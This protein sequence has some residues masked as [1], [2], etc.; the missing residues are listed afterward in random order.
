MNSKRNIVSAFILL[1]ILSGVFLL[2]KC[3]P[4][5]DKKIAELQT[6]EFTGDKTCKSC[7]EKEFT[8]WMQSHHFMAMQPATDSTVSGDFNNKTFTADGVTSRFYKKDGKFFINTVGEDGKNHDY[9]VKYTF[10]FTPLQQYLIEFPGGRMQATRQSWDVKEKKWF[11][12]YRAQN[13]SPGD[14][15]HWTGNGQNWNTMCASCH[16][17]NLQ[18][19]YHDASDSYKTSWSVINVSC[20]SCHGAGK[21]HIDYINSDEYK[22]G[23]RTDG[24]FLLLKKGTK[25]LA[26]INACAPCHARKSDFSATLV[27]SEELLDN[28]LPEIPTTE[29]FYAD[30]QVN[31]E[32]YIYTSFLQSKMFHRDVKCSNCHNPHSGKILFNDNRL[33][34]QCHAK[35]YD[36][37]FHTFHKAGTVQSEC[38]SCHMP[39][40]YYM[41]IDYR[42]DHSF[43]VPRPD[44]S[45]KYNIPNAC[46]NCHKDK[47]YQWAADA[48]VKWYG[49]NRRYH[50]SDNLIPGSELNAASESHL[51]KLLSDTAVPNIVKA[52]AANYLGNIPTQGSLQALLKCLNESDA[53]IRYRA[54]RSLANFPAQTWQQA[55][56]P[57]LTDKVIAVRVGTANLFIGLPEQQI[58]AQYLAAYNSARSELH[59]Y[60]MYQ[61]DFS[62]GNMMIA[63]YYLQLKDYVN[64]EKYY[65]KGLKKDNL[66]N[67]ARLNLSTVY[68]LM[69]RNEDALKVLDDA[70]KLDPGND[71]AYYN[72]GLLLYEMKRN[73]EAEKSFAKAVGLKS[74]N[75]R[76]YYNYGLLLKEENKLKE[77]ET[78]LKKGISINP[79]DAGL[80]YALVF[81]Y[82]EANDQS[83]ARSAAAKLK[84]MDPNNPE[85]ISLFKN[86]GL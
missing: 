13:I 16:S 43:R 4:Q 14:W 29:H 33:C 53:Q 77:A 82:I 74:Q 66:M 47:S 38:K 2:Q 8:E 76:V 18:K 39:G 46:N 32:D 44:Q 27:S 62:V 85:Y 84:Q 22:N 28:Y 71:R 61:A 58:P 73:N 11:H 57:L 36:S 17:T 7:H 67:Y 64:A 26:Q 15:L 49:P 19:N 51:L 10:G 37:S 72:R 68:N 65:L 52:T 45:V 3:K 31:D 55:V 40:K 9:E 34:L 41:E 30:G 56:L 6:N 1:F 78:I 70:V 25:Q 42:H 54:L 48:I 80:Y 20:E 63:D 75:P 79:S 12:Q 69:N 24:S 50:F 83:N 60:L 21:F 59:N 35:T 5:E 81:V 86:L 23:N